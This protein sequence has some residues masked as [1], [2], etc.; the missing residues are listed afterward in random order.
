MPHNPTAPTAN[1]P[2]TDKTCT[3]KTRPIVTGAEMPWPR[4][5]SGLSGEHDA[6]QQE[7]V[8]STSEHQTRVPIVSSTGKWGWITSQAGGREVPDNAECASREGGGTV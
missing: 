6:D 2:A 8:D 3:P 5:S 4:I 7:D 1:A